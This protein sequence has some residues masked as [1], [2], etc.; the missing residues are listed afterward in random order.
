MSAD[1]CVYLLQSLAMAMQDG[2]E[3]RQVEISRSYTAELL[4]KQLAPGDF[5]TPKAAEAFLVEEELD[6]GIIIGRG[7][8]VRF[9]HLSFQEFLAARAIAALR[10]RDQVQLLL[11]N[12]KKVLSPEWRETVLLLAGILHRQGPAKVR[13]MLEAVLETGPENDS[14]STQAQLV[15]LVGAVQRD[16]SALRFRL[17]HPRYAKMIKRV[18]GIFE[19]AASKVPIEIRL[20]AADAL[21]QAGD[22]R[23]GLTTW[24]NFP[25]GSLCDRRSGRGP[26][27]AILRCLRA[28][29]GNSAANGSIWPIRHGAISGHCG[30]VQPIY[31]GRR[32]PGCGDLGSRRVWEMGDPRQVGRS[33]SILKPSGNWY[34]L[35]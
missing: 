14:L 26:G 3:G 23:L 7:D 24:V 33:A 19:A 27:L 11:N 21:G 10:E 31:R 2:S 29:D 32:L 12:T 9:W 1:R 25:A 28:G 34:Q 5:A 35:V 15:G 8:N 22:P 4:F 13:A 30:R 18:M 20:E 16:L 17:E 6:S